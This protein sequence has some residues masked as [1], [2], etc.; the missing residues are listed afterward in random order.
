MPWL[1][2]VMMEMFG[3]T[4][5]AIDTSHT[6]PTPTGTLP[7]PYRDDDED[8]GKACR[9]RNSLVPAEG[10]MRGG[11]P[12]I[13][14]RSRCGTC[15]TGLAGNVRDRGPAPETPVPRYRGTT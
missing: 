14:V 4:I 3:G 1:W 15:G 5:I 6:S 2:L 9:C 13:R 10:R 7:P 8:E 11:S 12:L